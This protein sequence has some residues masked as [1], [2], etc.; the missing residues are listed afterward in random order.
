MRLDRV[1]PAP[2]KEDGAAG[3]WDALRRPL[4]WAVLA[5]FAAP[6]LFGG[7][8]LL[9]MISLLRERGFSAGDAA[10]VQAAIGASIIAGRLLSGAAMDRMSQLRPLAWPR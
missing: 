2:P 1:E 10:K 3:G 5:C 4:F 7:D 6:A 9:H 8:C